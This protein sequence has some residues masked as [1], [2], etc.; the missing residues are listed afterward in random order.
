MDVDR[1]LATAPP[2]VL[3]YIEK[4]LKSCRDIESRY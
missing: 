1:I 2:K 3:H 4:A